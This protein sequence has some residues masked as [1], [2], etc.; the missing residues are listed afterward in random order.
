VSKPVCLGDVV[1]NRDPAGVGVLDDGDGRF[2]VV[3][4]RLRK[5]AA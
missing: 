3:Y 4:L 1:S 5:P 2:G